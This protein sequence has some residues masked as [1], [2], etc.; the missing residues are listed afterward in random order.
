MKPNLGCC[1][2][3]EENESVKCPHFLWPLSSFLGDYVAQLLTEGLVFLPVP[4][5]E[6]RRRV[7]NSLALPRSFTLFSCCIPESWL[8]TILEFPFQ[9]L[10]RALHIRPPQ[11][12][13]HPQG[14]PQAGSP[15]G[16]SAGHCS[17]SLGHAGLTSMEQGPFLWVFSAE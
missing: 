10:V 6:V 4:G 13:C 16:S 12:P 11:G 2:A 17:R 1:T 7:V 8:R 14:W 9:R 15:S 5:R 3:P